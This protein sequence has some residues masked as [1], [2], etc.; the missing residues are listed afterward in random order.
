MTTGW[1][2]LATLDAEEFF[3]RFISSNFSSQTVAQDRL[4]GA[5][6]TISI[7][8]LNA[9]AAR[10]STKDTNVA[11]EVTTFT[12]VSTQQ[13]IG[14]ELQRSFLKKSNQNEQPENLTLKVI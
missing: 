6:Q 1:G 11:A 10:S 5:E 14:V 4:I 3:S 13:R 8:S 12:L 2:V 7:G 9:E